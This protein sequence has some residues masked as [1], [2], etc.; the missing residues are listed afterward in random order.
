[1]YL[2]HGE[3][4]QHFMSFTYKAKSWHKPQQCYSKVESTGLGMNIRHFSS[5]LPQKDAREIYFNFYVKRGDSSENRINPY[6]SWFV[7][8]FEYKVLF[9]KG[10]NQK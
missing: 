4:H 5:N 6:Y 10:F 7:F 9:L 8:Q 3:K 1:M 2:D